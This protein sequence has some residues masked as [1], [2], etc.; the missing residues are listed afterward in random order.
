MAAFFA[1]SAFSA[2]DDA[3]EMPVP[4]PWLRA[5]SNKEMLKRSASWIL[6]AISAASA[7]DCRSLLR[8]SLTENG[9]GVACAFSNEPAAAGFAVHLLRS[10][11]DK[12]GRFSFRDTMQCFS[13]DWIVAFFAASATSARDGR[14]PL[15]GSLAENAKEV[16]IR[17]LETSQ[18]R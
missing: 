9:R 5:E 11:Y 3:S 13:P 18:Y 14:S 4:Q 12:N 8:S 1:D 17:M 16:A 7:G 10:V 15:R 6:L 2:R